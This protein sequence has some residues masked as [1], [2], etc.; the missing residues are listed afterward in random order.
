MKKLCSNKIF[1]TALFMAFMITVF[2]L[3]KD[4]A[5]AAAGEVVDYTTKQTVTEMTPYQITTGD[6]ADLS[7]YGA[8][9]IFVPTTTGELVVP[10]RIPSKGLLYSLYGDSNNSTSTFYVDFYSDAACTSEV[11]YS[12]YTGF[13]EFPKEGIYYIKFKTYSSIP[14]TGDSA[15][16]GFDCQ[17]FDGS[18]TELKNKTWQCSGLIDSTTPIYYKVEVNK[19]GF[20]KVDFLSEYST[21]VTLC[22]SSKKEI[23][24]ECYISSSKPDAA[25]AV[26]KGT[27]YLKVKSNS[28][29]IRVRSSATAVT[30]ASGSSKSKAKALKIGSA[31]KGLLLPGDKTS[32]NDWFKFTLTKSTKLNLIVSGNVSSGK[33]R[34]E[35]TS[36]NIGGSI[37]GYLYQT[38]DSD[39]TSLKTWTTESLPRGTYYIRVYKDDSKTSGNYS[40]K[41][42][43][44]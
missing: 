24:D 4:Y 15:Y 22:S 1:K 43:K 5:K 42:A 30:D 10:I 20:I 8:Y 7:K 32:K 33:I 36:A 38:D 31:K 16:I 29:L 34:Y 17:F 23:S 2:A 37:T 11:S 28:D 3:N 6:E 44:R 39:T 26:K 21:Y 27:Y 18:N 35:L 12:S 25:F 40:I 41:V 14:V 9:D 19:T 13:A